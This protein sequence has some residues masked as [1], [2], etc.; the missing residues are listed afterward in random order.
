MNWDQTG[1]ISGWQGTNNVRRALNLQSIASDR[2]TPPML[3]SLDAEKAFV[4]LDWIFLEQTLARMGFHETFLSWIGVFHMN[5]RSRVRVN[6]Q[7]SEFFDVGQGTR[8]GDSL[9][10]ALFALSIEPLPELIRSNPLIQ[11]IRDEGGHQHKIAL[12]ADDILLFIENPVHSIP[13]LLQNLNEYGLVSGY[14][15]NQSKSE[16]MMMSGPWPSQLDD[17]VSFRGP[18]Q[19]FR[20]LWITLSPQVTQL[21]TTNYKKLFEAFRDELVRWDV[22]PLSLLGRVEAVKMNLL[23]RLLFPLQ[24]LPVRIPTLAFNMLDKLIS[25]FIWQNK[26]PRV[27]L[28][29]LTL[30][31]N[32]GGLSLPNTKYYFWA[33]QLTA[34]VAWINNDTETGWVN[35]EQNSLPAIP[36]SALV[37]L[38]SPRKKW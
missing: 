11:G 15:V 9:S 31:K 19:G 17:I 30:Q 29:T 25:R 5:P 3:L 20:Y 8:Q 38:N 10:P 12:Y 34:V 21:Y 35:L 22:L 27:Q 32:R 7:C 1:F 23:P 28:K 24:S 14:K 37:F 33:A 13:A 26:R 4:R 36:L 2:K 18:K 16:A 6:G